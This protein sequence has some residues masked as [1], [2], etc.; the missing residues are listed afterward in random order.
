MF[1]NTEPMTPLRFLE[2]SAEV[3]PDRRAVVHGSR[4]WTYREFQRD[5]HRFATALLPLVA[6]AQ[7]PGPEGYRREEDPAEGT[8]RAASSTSEEFQGVDLLERDWP[9]VAMV[10]P[11]VPAALMAHYAVPAAGAVLVP[12]NPRSVSYTHLRA[13]ETLS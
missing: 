8:S 7:S 3:F 2:R 9:T 6:G 12:L 11:N 5:V 13:H 10:A 4:E 1:A